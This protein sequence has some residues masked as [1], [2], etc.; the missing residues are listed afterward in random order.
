M[1]IDSRAGQPAIPSDLVDVSKLTA[2][3]YEEQPDPYVSEQRVVFGTS[4]GNP[5]GGIKVIAQSGWF[6]ARPS[7]SEEIYKIYAESFSGQT[8]LE[9]IK[10]EAQT[11]IGNVFVTTALVS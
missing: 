4:D 5:I 3:Y 2:A 11:I 6:A 9:Q 1:K 7:G 8:H 10:E